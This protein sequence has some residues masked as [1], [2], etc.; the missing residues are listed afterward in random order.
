MAQ[1]YLCEVS[2]IFE[3]GDTFEVEVDV[4]A[5]LK[6]TGKMDFSEGNSIII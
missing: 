3:A 6:L 4:E 5:I 1:Q 2:D